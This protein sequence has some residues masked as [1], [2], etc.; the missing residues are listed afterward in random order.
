MWQ[1][2]VNVDRVRSSPGLVWAAGLI[3]SFCG[4]TQEM[5][6]Q[7]RL[8]PLEAGPTPGEI[9][10]P[11]APV[12]G[13]VARG[14]HWPDRQFTTGRVEGELATTLPEALSDYF[15]E[16][17]LLRRGAQRY[18]IF[19]SHC[20]GLTGGGRGGDVAYRPQVGMVVLRGFP[21]P[22]TYHQPRLRAAPLGHFFDVITHGIGRMPAHGY[23][24]PPEDRWAIAVYVKALQLSQHAPRE[25]L[26]AGD[27]ERLSASG[28]EHE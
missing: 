14:Q 21:T 2:R 20:H 15:V 22:P 7:P 23:L 17:E 9:A 18:E 4:C 27:L 6:N 13:T 8:E 19:C 26:T 1:A 16:D 28:G 11:R 25:L 24:I 10:P 3:L 5:A 12:P